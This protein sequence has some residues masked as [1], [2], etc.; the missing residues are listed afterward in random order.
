MAR[1]QGQADQRH[2]G[3]A[4]IG[5]HP[6]A[7]VG[8]GATLRQG[9]HHEKRVVLHLTEAGDPG[10]LVRAAIGERLGHAVH[11]ALD[12]LAAD[13]PDPRARR[14]APASGWSCRRGRG[15]TPR[16]CQA[17]ENTRRSRPVRSSRRRCRR[18]YPSGPATRW[19]TTIA[20]LSPPVPPIYS[21][22]PPERCTAKKGSPA[23]SAGTAPPVATRNR[24]VRAI[25]HQPRDV[26]Q[27]AD[28]DLQVALDQ[29]GHS[30]RVP[31]RDTGDPPEIRQQEIR[32]LDHARD[33]G[34]RPD[35]SASRRSSGTSA[36]A[37]L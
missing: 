19:L 33:G 10:P 32:R 29:N 2:C 16:R 18:S 11:D 15:R 35:A 7:P 20:P 25:D 13:G 3:E 1:E 26:R 23:T 17:S 14:A 5:Q 28:Q 36:S 27:L 37:R 24:P 31:V 12:D 34:P 22:L 30:R 4:G 21:A 6:P 9:D 8:D